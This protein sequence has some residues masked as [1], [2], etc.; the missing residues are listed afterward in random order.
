M[1]MSTEMDKVKSFLVGPHIS[2]IGG[3][4]VFRKFDSFGV[5]ISSHKSFFPGLQVKISL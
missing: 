2:G 1:E 5:I 3:L 4:H